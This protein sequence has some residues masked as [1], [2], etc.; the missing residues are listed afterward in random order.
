MRGQNRL[1]LKVELHTH[2]NLDP[3]DRIPHSSREL[4]DRA[5]AL[6]F[7]ALAITLHD[8]FYD[9]SPDVP[10]ARSRGLVLLPGIE[11]AIGHAH[12][13]LINFPASCEQVVS[14]DDV[15]QLKSDH[16][17]GLVIAPHAAYPIA[18]AVGASTLEQHADLFDAIEV[19]AM[20]TR[21]LDF[22]RAAIAWAKRHGKPLVG[23]ADVHLLGQLGTT[24]SLVDAAPDP[25]AICD[26]IKAGRVEVKTQPIS[27][28][29]AV[30]TFA[31]MAVIGIRGRARRFGRS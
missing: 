1:V 14:Y 16:P 7:Q 25:D 11:R 2:T 27:M 17:R 18:S 23:N 10:Y 20:Y 29:R 24:Y 13:L 3:L 15:R 28:T 5:A 19:N 30:T 6:G 9:P 21:H 26:A 22:N 31:R 12:V 8:R 4:I